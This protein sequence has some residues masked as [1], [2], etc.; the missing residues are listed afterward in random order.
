M[1]VIGFADQ[2]SFDRMARAVREVE[3]MFAGSNLGPGVP[4]VHGMRAVIVRPKTEPD[5]HHFQQ[6]VFVYR[7]LDDLTSTTTTSTTT[8]ST[9]TTTSTTTTTTTTFNPNTSTTTP[10]PCGTTS[11]TTTT[12]TTGDPNW[13]ESKDCLI[14]ESNNRRLGIGCVFDGHLIGNFMGWPIILVQSNDEPDDCQHPVNPITDNTCIGNCKWNW[15]P[16]VRKWNQVYSQCCPKDTCKCDEPQICPTAACAAI[17]TNCTASAPQLQKDCTCIGPVTTPDPSTSTTPDPSTSTT[18]TTTTT[19]DPNRCYGCDW[20]WVPGLGYRA[21]KVQCA[22]TNCASWCLSPPVA[23]GSVC[24]DVHTPCAPPPPKPPKPPDCGGTCTFV[25]DGV[26]WVQTY[27]GCRNSCV[28]FIGAQC[29]CPYPSAP[30]T[31]CGTGATTFCSC[32]GG[33]TTSTSYDPNAPPPSTTKEPC[34]TTTRSTGCI[35]ECFW[36][37]SSQQALWLLMNSNCN[38]ACGCA[39]PGGTGEFDCQVKVTNC[40]DPTTT[41]PPPPTTTSTT[42]TTKSPCLTSYCNQIVASCAPII[43]GG[44]TIG[45]TVNYNLQCQTH[46]CDWPFP[47]EIVLVP[48]CPQCAGGGVQTIF[49]ASGCTQFPVGYCMGGYYNCNQVSPTTTTSTTPP[50]PSTTPGGPSTT[51]PGPTTTTTTTTSTTPAPKCHCWGGVTQITNV[52]AGLCQYAVGS[53]HCY[54]DASPGGTGYTCGFVGGPDSCPPFMLTQPCGTLALQ[55][56]VRGPSCF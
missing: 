50:G 22:G 2:A 14:L 26:R 15:D 49:S 5:E 30:P 40:T 45:A 29:S 4:Q 20:R 6:G 16:A 3:K 46:S 54:A 10:D 13:R 47:N 32:V 11:T 42:S 23:G 9:S 28:N 38:V 41:T 1:P 44:S 19:E 56:T 27:Y 53:T 37:W 48:G 17:L 7:R 8:T 18:T 36:T 35:G 33:N 43:Q 39:Q 25:A 34:T 12:T 24:V 55:Q 21:L 31:N 52:G 51:P